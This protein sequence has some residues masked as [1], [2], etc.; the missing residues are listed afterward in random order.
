[1]KASKRSQLENTSP[2]KHNARWA[3]LEKR[4]NAKKTCKYP[5]LSTM[6][7]PSTFVIISTLMQPFRE[8]IKLIYFIHCLPCI[9]K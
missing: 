7:F 3:P 8:Q 2:N 5:A 4:E 6:P 9:F 1:M